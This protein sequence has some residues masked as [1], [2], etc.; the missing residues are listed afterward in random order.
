MWLSRLKSQRIVGVRDGRLIANQVVDKLNPRAGVLFAGPGHTLFVQ[1]YDGAP[2]P[3]GGS[4]A[5]GFGK[6]DRVGVSPHGHHR[7]GRREVTLGAGDTA[8]T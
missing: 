3:F 1:T 8:T 6:L 5:F 2:T 4:P 7:P